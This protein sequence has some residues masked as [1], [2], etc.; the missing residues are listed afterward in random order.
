VASYEELCRT[1]GQ[2]PLLPR[3]TPASNE[4]QALLTKVGG[5]TGKY[6]V[7]ACM[8]RLYLSSYP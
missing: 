3:E 8:G 2:F 1:H 4:L 5:W 6:M 7:L